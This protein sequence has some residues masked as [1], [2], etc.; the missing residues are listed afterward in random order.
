MKI[1]TEAFKK[2]AVEKALLKPDISPRHT[3]KEIGISGSA[4]YCWIREYG[5]GRGM[6]QS[7]AKKS[8]SNWTKEEQFNILLEIANLSE[9]ACGAYCRQKGL[10]QH[11]LDQWREDFMKENKEVE[12]SKGVRELKA[13][14]TENKALKK[15]L[16]RKEKALAEVAALL[17]LKKKAALIWGENEDD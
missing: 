12:P 9:E 1:Y 2:A 15:E 11:Q 14:R 10:Y 7:S 17:V 13:L 8:P 3:A 5:R 16:N 4:L 6:K